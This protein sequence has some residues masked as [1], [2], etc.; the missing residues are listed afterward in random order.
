MTRVLLANLIQETCSFATTKFDLDA[1]H[2]YYLYFGDEVLEKLKGSDTEV[3]GIIAVAAEE[4]VDLVPSV[5]TFAGTG[6]PVTDEAYAYLR[7]RVLAVA[8][9]EASRLD[10]AILALHG[11]MVTESIDDPEGD[12]IAAVREALGPEKPVV[13]GLDLHGHITGRMVEQATAL[14]GYHTH[15]HVDFYDTGCRAMRLLARA[16]RGEV[17]PVMGH[18][19]L[20]MITAAEKH[21]TSREP[22]LPIVQRLLAAEREPGIL[23]AAVF[24]VQAQIDVPG[25]GWSVVTVADGDRALAQRWADE[26]GELAWERRRQFLVERTPIPEALRLARETEGG[27]VVLA[28]S[29]DATSGGAE[30]DS[31]WLLRGL[32]ESP[33]P[34]R[35]LLMMV[36]PEAVAA[37]AA[38]GVRAE[39]TLDVG[40]KLAPAF[41]Q[42]VQVTGVVKTLHDGRYTMKLPAIP[43]DRGRT[44]VLEIG[45]ISLV[46]FERPVYTWDEEFYRTVGLFPRE[47]KV[48]QVKS[49]GG[50]RPIYEPFAKLILE[51]DAPGPTDSNL[52]RLPYRRVSRP[53]FPLDDM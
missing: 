38:A 5:A 44:A 14:V 19:K 18:R 42:P 9:R 37:C 2:R 51:I 23:A 8:R 12:L 33:V 30:G 17:K 11:A 29:S 24:T 10:G 52:A 49:P 43:A 21:N 22:M 20:P 35:S 26:I 25:L 45:E 13:C 6:G 40:G 4:G 36:D 3:G 28:D 15:P 46:L 50:F 32:L 39:V 1:F 16:L 27:P 31:T 47:A 48:V 7:E 41:S 34:G 53:L